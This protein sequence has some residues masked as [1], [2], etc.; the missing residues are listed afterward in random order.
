M[1]SGGIVEEMIKPGNSSTLL[2]LAKLARVLSL[3]T[4]PPVESPL[5]EM[6]FSGG[7]VEEMIKLANRSP[8]LGL[9]KLARVLS[10]ATGPPV[11]SPLAYSN[12]AWGFGV[13]GSGT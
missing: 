10:L 12:T 13:V 9:A 4:G 2:G 6:M 3:A 11:E 5:E 8:L 7:L 1:F